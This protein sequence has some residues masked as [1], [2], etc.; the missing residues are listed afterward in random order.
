MTA[1][2]IRGARRPD[3]EIRRRRLLLRK[4]PGGDDMIEHPALPFLQRDE[5]GKVVSAAEAVKLIRDGDTLATGGFVGIGFA[6]EIAIA[7][8]QRFLALRDAD[9][10]TVGHPRDLTLVY[11]AGQGDGRERGLNH[12]A[13]EGLVKR[14]VGGHWGLVPK[15]Q[16]FAVTNQIEAYN[17]PQGVITH[18]F[19]DIAAH[20][21]AHITRIGLGTFVDPRNGGGKLNARTTEDLV[22]LVSIEG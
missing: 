1:T 20:R 9:T 2:S 19:R 12:L 14:I 16:H 10:S 21:P 18:L 7:I 5:K 11:A 3:D 22:H 8:E 15:L 17:L 6:E 4:R 13:H